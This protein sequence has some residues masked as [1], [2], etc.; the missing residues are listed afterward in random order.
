[1]AQMYL[2]WLLLVKMWP[3]PPTSWLSVRLPPSHSIGMLVALTTLE[4]LSKMVDNLASY[5]VYSRH[6]ELP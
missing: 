5:P 1:M 6:S 4:K 2:N 3:L